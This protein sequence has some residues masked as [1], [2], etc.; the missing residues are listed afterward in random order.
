[1]IG[2][3]LPLKQCDWRN[4]S[5]MLADDATWQYWAKV[6]GEATDWSLWIV[7]FRSA[8]DVNN[9]SFSWEPLM[10]TYGRWRH[11]GKGRMY[12]TEE[13]MKMDELVSIE[14]VRERFPR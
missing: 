3:D 8:Q 11:M 4:P 5:F 14:L 10:H 13:V 1:M 9:S 7:S 12:T 6:L 2:R